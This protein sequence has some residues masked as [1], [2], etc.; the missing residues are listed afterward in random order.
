MVFA[1]HEEG[2]GFRLESL[3]TI[4]KKVFASE[5]QT[6][7]YYRD[8]LFGI[9][10]NDAGAMKKQLVCYDLERG[11]SWAS[12]NTNRFGLGP[13]L[14]AGGR[15]YILRDDCVLILAEAG[16]SAYVELAKAKVLEG[17]DAWAPMALA[18]GR[19]LLRDLRELICLDVAV[20]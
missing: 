9:L 7:I 16:T 10:P 11:V 5:Q 4:D 3:A 8:H 18:G 14:V 20:R 6:P 2:E 13:Y 1:V 19:L 15:L 17:R 12:G